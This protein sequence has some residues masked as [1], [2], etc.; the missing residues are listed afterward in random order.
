MFTKS[1]QKNQHSTLDSANKK[2]YNIVKNKGREQKEDMKNIQKV[3]KRPS[4][5][6]QV[7]NCF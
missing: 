1:S 2:D 7:D 3:L 4:S 5:K 6:K